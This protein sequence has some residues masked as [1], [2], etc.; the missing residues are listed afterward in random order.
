[1]KIMINRAVRQV[2]TEMGLEVV[3][4]PL[5][6]VDDADLKGLPHDS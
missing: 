1:M 4:I 2:A 3:D 5:V 6:S